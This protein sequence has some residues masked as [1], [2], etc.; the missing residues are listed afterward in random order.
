MTRKKAKFLHSSDYLIMNTEAKILVKDIFRLVQDGKVIGTVD[1]TYN[2]LECPPE[3][4]QMKFHGY[5]A[6]K[7]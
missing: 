4:H 1:A 7:T 3:Y 5:V 6:P 2:F